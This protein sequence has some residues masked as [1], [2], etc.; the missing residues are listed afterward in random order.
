MRILVVGDTHGQKGL[1]KRLS[2]YAASTGHQMILQVGDFGF[3]WHQ[4]SDGSDAWL[5]E[6]NQA[7][8]DNEIEWCWIDGNHDNHPL[9]WSKD[10][11]MAA[12]TYWPRGSTGTFGG[13][14]CG[15]LGGA[16]SVDRYGRK[17][18]KSWWYTEEITDDELDVAIAQF[19]LNRVKV[20]FTHDAPT[21]APALKHGMDDRELAWTWP[22]DLLDLSAKSRAKLQRVMDR[23]KPELWVHGHYHYSYTADI[24]GTK[25]IGLA[26]ADAY[27]IKESTVSLTLD[28]ESWKLNKI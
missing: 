2:H 17:L 10:H 1:A 16:V 25:V 23:I 20:V 12:T 3:G 22:S 21:L 18:G 9:L 6:V 8:I 5:M 27:G 19:L 26:N 28:G 24:G 15:F 14:K 4:L 13:V 7:A 11:D